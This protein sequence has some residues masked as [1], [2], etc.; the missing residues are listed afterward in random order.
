MDNL[1]QDLKFGLR[2]LAKNPGFTAVAI[3]TLA[4]GIG[5]NTAI[6]S[7]I[8]SALLKTLPVADPDRLVTV[9]STSDDAF[10]YPAFKQL[11][12]RNQVFSG[13]V[14]FRSFEDFDFEVDGHA[15]LAKAQVVSGNYYSVLGVGAILG[16]TIAPDDDRVAGGGPVAVISYDYWIRR[17]DRDPTVVGKKIALNGSPFTIV[18]VTPPDFSGLAPGNPYEVAIPINM[19]AQVRPEWA[20]AGTPYSVLSAPF[21]NWLYL[22]ARLKPGVT[23]EQA[24]ANADPIY[25]QSM[26]EAA[27]GMSGLSVDSARTREIYRGFRMHL[28]PGGRGTA[29]LRQQFS[30]PL[31]I[32]MAV[33][34]LLLLITCANVAGLMLARAGARHREIAV[35]IALGAGRWR[36]V[37]QLITESVLLALGGAAL[38]MFLA[39]WA[40]GVLLAAVSHSSSPVSLNVQPDARV[41]AFTIFVS[42]CTAILFGL[43]PAVR[44]TQ[45]RLAGLQESSRVVGDARHRSGLGKALV[46][47]QVTLSLVLLVGA[48]LLVRTLEKLKDFNPGFNAEH[49]LLVSVNPSMVGY[50]EA[51]ATGLYQRLVA[52]IGALPGVR[53]ASFSD[54]SPLAVRY[55]YTL[56]TVEGYTPRPG[57]STPVMLNVIGPDY[58][59]V[60]QTPVLLGREFTEADAAGAPRVGIINQAMAHYYF[61]DANPIGRRFSVPGWRGDSS[62]LEIVGVIQDAKYHNLRQP[63]PPQAYIPFL[64]APESGSTTLEVR[65]AIDPAGLATAV[66]RVILQADSRLP[67]FDVKTLTEQVEESLV[68]DRLVASLSGLFGLLAL[69]LAAIGLY[70]LMAHTVSRRTNEIGV[71]MALGAR[72][73]QILGMMMGEALALAILGAAIGIPIALGA[74]RLIRSE[75]YGLGPG[76]P[77]TVLGTTVLMLS[78]AGLAGYLPARR[79]TKVDPMVA[80]RYQ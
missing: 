30:K 66:R 28:E 57:E 1:L 67:I 75:L 47:S 32:L 31:L 16:R 73:E 46:V 49:V 78:V 23:Q 6:F 74:T 11:Q 64:Q 38:G 29:A 62:W 79:A 35:R 3:V 37:R 55:S 65:A 77:L 2:M 60:L 20:V 7:L 76:D 19:V 24:L 27:E 71:R 70:G 33:V 63:A 48:G 69:L 61:G 13:V 39:F 36:L 40:T 56:P 8:N 58:F 15:G 50:K 25:R 59:R 68:Q 22:M 80:L 34:G 18:G 52:G 12:D 4:L 51:Q 14:A 42:L 9:G 10:P 54:F 26:R 53:V 72:R 44:V 21:R 45:P 43:A 41:L 5:A 17:F